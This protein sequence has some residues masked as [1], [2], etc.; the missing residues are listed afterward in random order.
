MSIYDK[1]DWEDL[2]NRALSCI[3]CAMCRQTLPS[4]TKNN[5]YADTCPAGL[6]FNFEAYYPP[7]R[8]EIARA[9]I[10]NEYPLQDSEKLQEVIFSCTTC[11]A[12][13][14]HCKYIV[15][16]NV[17]PTDIMEKI[18]AKLVKEGI[19]PLPAQ[20][21]FSENVK[22]T[23]NPYGEI[24]ERNAWFNDIAY[25]DKGSAEIFYFVGCTTGFR[26]Q[27][28]GNNT[29]SILKNV[30]ADFTIS[31]KEICCGSPL[32]R[33]GQLDQVEELVKK[34]VELI[35]KTGSKTVLFSCAGC[36]RTVSRDWPE[37]LGKELPFNTIHI[38][39]F[40]ANKIENKKLKFSK[41]LNEKVV[42]HDPCH[43][44]RHM[45]PNR[46][47]EQPR[48]VLDNIPGIERKIFYREKDESLCCAA[49]GGVKAGM[50]EFSE[51]IAAL[52]VD[53]ARAVGAET[54]VTTCPFCI[55][56]LSDGAEKEAKD[57]GKTKIKVKSLTRLI[58]EALGGINHE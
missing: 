4:E 36:Y 8:N 14:I 38:S 9:I 5:A 26:Q 23:K 2:K 41:K 10:R 51:Y 39:E 47:Y 58:N 28:L 32:I 49:G 7:G 1:I 53:E 31:S 22:Q 37:I 40:A 43:L 18:R 25:K 57:S 13:E 15:D 29:V 11:G 20:I 56:G 21:K 3:H 52:R 42:Y 17:C 16:M 45:H 54:I 50:P 19:G 34:N 35:K 12:C 24:T 33:T 55:R 27:E 46:V 30:K 48:Y 6:Y 44:G